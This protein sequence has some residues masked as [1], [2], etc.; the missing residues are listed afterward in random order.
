MQTLDQLISKANE[1][2]EDK[3]REA[4][5][6][7][8]VL[9]YKAL[10]KYFSRYDLHNHTVFVFSGM[11]TGFLGIAR[12]VP[13]YN[14]LNRYE[15]DDD[16]YD[17]MDKMPEGYWEKYPDGDYKIDPDKRLER[18]E[19]LLHKKEISDIC[20]TIPRGTLSCLHGAFL[21]GPALGKCSYAKSHKL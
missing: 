18:V 4:E 17:R 13:D 15:S 7:A 3:I 8:S 1:H 21:T 11:G 16:F 9:M 5:E 2:I 12:G 10:V 20:S 19:E 6:K 14:K